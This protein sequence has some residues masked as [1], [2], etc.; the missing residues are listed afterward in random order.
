MEN[1]KN[2][3]QG[4]QLALPFGERKTHPHNSIVCL[5]SYKTSKLDEKENI[6]KQKVINKLIAHANS[7]DW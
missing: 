6:L 7:L 4:I 5:K 3:A 2:K 1:K